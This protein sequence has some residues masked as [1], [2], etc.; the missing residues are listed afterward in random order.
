MSRNL[1]CLGRDLY[2]QTGTVDP[3]LGYDPNPTAAETEDYLRIGVAVVLVGAFGWLIWDRYQANQLA[4]Q[5]SEI[6][7]TTP[8]P[9]GQ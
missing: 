9:I 5:L 7:Q 3:C 4:Q 6:S 8:Q 2:E 1:H